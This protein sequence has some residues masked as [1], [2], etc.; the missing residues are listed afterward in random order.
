MSGI[1]YRTL[2]RNLRITFAA[3]STCLAASLLLSAC[4]TESSGGLPKPA[5]KAERAEAQLA[6]AR[7][8][9]GAASWTNAKRSLDKAIALDAS[10]PEAYVLYAVAFEAEGEL[11]LAEANYRK[12]LRLAAADPQALSNYGNFLQ[13]R[14]RHDDAA[15]Q[16]GKVVKNTE[17]RARPEAYEALGLTEIARGRTEEVAA[18]FER[19]LSLNDRLAPSE[20][21]LS[22][23]AFDRNDLP[24]AVRRCE[25]YRVI[26]KPTARSLCLG[27]KIGGSVGNSDQ[28][29]SNALA[30]KNLFPNSREAKSCQVQSQ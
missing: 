14:G 26:G 25:R 8:Y 20:L 3:F 16:L 19:A 12:A 1:K 18:A 10:L 5:P 29:A 9:I 22:W 4:V 23:I 2:L 11:E 21:E 6:V 17:Y 13:R 28:V 30:L 24:N 27:M 15:V 7:G